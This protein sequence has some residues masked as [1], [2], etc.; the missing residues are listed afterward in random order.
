MT[1]REKMMI[2]AYIPS[3][4]DPDLP[5]NEYYCRDINERIHRVYIS[6]ICPGGLNEGTFYGVRYSGSGKRFDSGDGFGRTR[7]SQLYDSK[8][9]CRDMTHLGYE[10]WEKLRMLQEKEVPNG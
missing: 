6:D 2:E 1:E 7:M 9:D 5:E 4:R 8:A 3:P 10:G